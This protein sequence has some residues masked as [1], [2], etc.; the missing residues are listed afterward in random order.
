M[1]WHFDVSGELQKEQLLRATSVSEK[2]LWTSV[3]ERCVESGVNIMEQIRQQNRAKCYSIQ[4][5]PHIFIVFC[6][7][8]WLK[9]LEK[10]MRIGM[11]ET[12]RYAS[13]GFFIVDL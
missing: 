7:K 6:W 4:E 3:K 10:Q 5:C 1:V 8:T 13:S 9:V 12:L 11:V 2:L